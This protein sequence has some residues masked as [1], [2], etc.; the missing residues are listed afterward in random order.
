MRLSDAIAT[1]RVL[2]TP[3]A[4]TLGDG[5]KGCALGMAIMSGGLGHLLK[6]SHH[7]NGL[8]WAD[9]RMKWPIMQYGAV[10]PPIRGLGYKILA[11]ESIITLLFD[12]Y[13]MCSYFPEW[14]LDRLIDWVR[15]VEDL[16]GFGD[17]PEVDK[18][19][20]TQQTQLEVA[21]NA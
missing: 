4:G 13:V 12:N 6:G 20:L 3:W 17:D 7:S 10:V 5:T 15:E 16:F 19:A 1:G 8:L 14:T 9:M 18:V 11:V 2:I 21:H